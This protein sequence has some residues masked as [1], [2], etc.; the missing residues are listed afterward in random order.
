M[1]TKV[2]SFEVT[3]EGVKWW[4]DADSSRFMVPDLCSSRVGLLLFILGT[5]RMDWL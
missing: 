5:Y 4:Q 1:I 3:F 2:V